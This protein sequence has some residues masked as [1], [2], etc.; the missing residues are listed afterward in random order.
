MDASVT[1][2]RLSADVW[3]RAV[4]GRRGKWVVVLLGIALAGVLGPLAGKLGPLE[5]SSSASFLP[6]GADST[7]VSDYEAAHR[8]SAPLPAIVVFSR[9]TGLTAR[10]RVAIAH[11]REASARRRLAGAATP[12]AVRIS[13]DGRA[14]L[15]VVPIASGASRTTVSADVTSIRSLLVRCAGAGARPPA[16]RRSRLVAVVGGPAGAAADAVGAFAGINGKL[17]AVTVVIVAILLLLIYRSPLLWLVPLA[18]VGLAAG[19]SQGAAYGLARMG[20]TI[21]GMVVGILSVLVF[22]AGT[23]YALLL[24]ARY[25]EELGRH[26]DHHEAM[27]VA[28]RRAGPAILTSGVTVVLALLCLLVAQLSDVAA[29]G[30][31][32]AVGIVCALLAQLAVLPALLAIVGRRAFWPFVPRPGRPARH[33]EGAWARI[34]AWLTAH[35]RPVW[36]ALTAVLGVCAL[37]LLAYRG[38]VN[39]QNGFRTQVGSVTAQRLLDRGF[40]LAS[41]APAVVLVRPPSAAA[42][43]RRAARATP[44]VTAVGDPRPVGDGRILDV[45]LAAPPA[46]EAAQHAVTALRA[47]VRSAGGPRTLVGGETATNL[48]LAAAAAHDRAVIVPIVLAVVLVMLVLLLRALVAP[49]ALVLS[50]LLSYVASLGV[51]AIV[52]RGLFGFIGFDPSVPIFGFVFLVALGVDYNIFLMARA[53]EEA[54]TWGTAGVA[55]SL[56][57]TGAVISSAGVVLAATFAVLGV[58]PLVALTEVGFLVAFGVLVDTLLVRGALVPALAIDV[59]LAWWWPSSPA[60]RRPP[61]E[62]TPPLQ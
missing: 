37:G 21:N 31:V 43:V 39:Q 17:L 40:P 9:S 5:K 49:I 26:E 4:T 12:G 23:D 11:C 45:L 28:L 30:P 34:G 53:R 8:A 54:A 47:R 42:A 15:F 3:V 46:S 56:A 16:P 2:Y 6:A 13:A 50:V 7:R 18:S 44:G 52:F 10:D 25:R 59:G 36:F 41:G 51:S 14:A 58:L 20:F 24:I 22:G 1:P 29:L 27:A 35:P 57:V 32:C 33:A 55:R 38:G 62:R 48:D 60:A 61:R 19:W